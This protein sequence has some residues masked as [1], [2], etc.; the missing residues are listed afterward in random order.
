M[1]S[2]PGFLQPEDCRVSWAARP[3]QK[4]CTNHQH[5]S[6]LHQGQT[7][8]SRAQRGAREP[9]PPTLHT[10]GKESTGDLRLD[11]TL[12]QGLP[13]AHGSKAGS[14]MD[15]LGTDTS[16]GVT[17]V[18]KHTGGQAWPLLPHWQLLGASPGQTTALCVLPLTPV[19]IKALQRGSKG[20]EGTSPIWP[21]NW[22]SEPPCCRDW[23]PRWKRSLCLEL[24][25]GSSSLLR[26][27]CYC[28]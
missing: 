1:V 11:T 7:R 9:Q 5:H 12:S 18:L 3:H 25:N 19:S 21:S 27:R 20:Q 14:G 2:P 10:A 17:L 23:A 16:L 15:S 13:P 8:R 28:P 4:G 6:W 24:W 22:A 26:A